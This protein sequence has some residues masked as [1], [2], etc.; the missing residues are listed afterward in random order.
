MKWSDKAVK[1]YLGL[2]AVSSLILSVIA[3]AKWH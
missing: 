3:N 1:A 2:L